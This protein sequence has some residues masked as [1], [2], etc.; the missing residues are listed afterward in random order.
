[1]ADVASRKEQ[2]V[3]NWIESVLGT[4]LSGGFESALKDGQVLCNL[5]NKIRPNTILTVNNY[6]AAFRQMQ[7]IDNFLK[8]IEKLGV[9]DADRFKTEDLY[10]A[11]NIPKV[12]LTLSV[13]SQI[14]NEKFGT[15]PVVSDSGLDELRSYSASSQR[16]DGKKRE[17]DTGL[18]IFETGM[19]KAQKE[20]SAVNRTNDRMVHK[21][22]QDYAAT[23]ELGFIDKD[24]ASHQALASTAH[25]KG[26]DQI[27]RSKD[28]A[29]AT[30]EL[31]FIDADKAKHQALASTAHGRGMDQILRSK[32]QAVATSELGFIDKDKAAHQ[33][34][35]SK[36]HGKGM[37]QIIR[38]KDEAVAS[39]ELGF[40]DADKAKHQALAST[41][42]GRGMD[43]IIRSKDEAVAT[44]ELGFIDADK[45]KHQAL[46]SQAHGRGMDHIVRTDDAGSSV[47][48]MGSSLR[49][50]SFTAVLFSKLVAKSI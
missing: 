6:K 36:A 15:T 18:S 2:E 25:G 26:M 27:L 20:A 21:D 7:N 29:V 23:N 12:V 42:H 33:A 49:I 38:S 40:I 13:L 1:M 28:Q 16:A 3:Q 50:S 19:K 17:I 31:G 22:M 39:S 37:D 45:S 35:A 48:F 10:Y 24:K 5:I 11:N 4:S 44:S 32:D 46:A 34:L 41:A 9:S 8:V 30:S 14:V 47:G 43:Q